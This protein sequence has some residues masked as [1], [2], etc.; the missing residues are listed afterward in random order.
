[1]RR[2]H[3]VVAATVLTVLVGVAGCADTE[4]QGTDAAEQP[5]TSPG[6]LGDGG[7]T[8][9]DGVQ[10]TADPEV[11]VET[12]EPTPGQ[13]PTGGFLTVQPGQTGQVPWLAPPENE[14][15]QPVDVE[16]FVAEGREAVAVLTDL[17]AYSTGVLLDVSVRVDPASTG[18]DEG[19]GPDPLGMVGPIGSSPRASDDLL[20]IE[21]TY[22]DGSVASTEDQGGPDAGGGEPEGPLLRQSTSQGAGSSWEYDL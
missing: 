7:G 6:S 11:G 9:P 2:G 19:L 12:V 20:R 21:V 18:S 1:M 14:L 22:P 16:R 17:T 15:G 13:Q 4:E 8:A 5:A 3:A 10:P